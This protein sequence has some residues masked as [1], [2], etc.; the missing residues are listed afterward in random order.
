[1]KIK[2]LLPLAL[3]LALASTA[4]SRMSNGDVH[5]AS[6]T[7][8]GNQEVELTEGGL[9]TGS[10]GLHHANIIEFGASRQQVLAQLTPILGRPR[11]GRNADCPTGAVDTADYG[12]LH[13]NFQ[14]GRFAGW[15]VDRVSRPALETYHGFA[16]G[17]RRSEIDLDLADLEVVENSTLGTEIN[18]FG[19]GALLE[20]PGPNARV[21][22][23]FSGV[24]CFAR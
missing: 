13:L 10:A 15:V 14:D 17:Q 5:S 11:L 23:L 3:G 2:T 16:V 18:A 4:C 19:V 21:K 8:E 12:A 24:T 20:G 6:A 22:T 1:M 7:P 9:T